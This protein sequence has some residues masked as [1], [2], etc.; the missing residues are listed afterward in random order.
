M[1]GV[2][3]KEVELRSSKEGYAYLSVAQGSTLT[4]TA[5]KQSV[6][7]TPFE[8]NDIEWLVSQAK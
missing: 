4:V 5:L 7:K 8:L 2:E 3:V 6:K 1:E